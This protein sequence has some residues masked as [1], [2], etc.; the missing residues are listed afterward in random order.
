M[1]TKQMTEMLKELQLF[2][3]N[4]SFPTKSREMEENPD[5]VM[6][7]SFEIYEIFF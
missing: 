4:Y 6:R 2:M 1:T 7:I 3:D 5:I